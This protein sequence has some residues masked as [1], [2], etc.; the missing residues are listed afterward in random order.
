MSKDYLALPRRALHPPVNGRTGLFSASGKKL[1]EIARFSSL[2][3]SF[4]INPAKKKGDRLCKDSTT[5]LD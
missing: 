1:R 2:W 4:W 5:D 3:A